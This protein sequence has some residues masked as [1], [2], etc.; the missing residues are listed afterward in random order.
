MDLNG[1]K[2]F[3]MNF[4]ETKANTKLRSSKEQYL[5]ISRS[6]SKLEFNFRSTC[7]INLFKI[8]EVDRNNCKAKK[9]LQS[10]HHFDVPHN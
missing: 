1:S 5:Q 6:N 8:K 7:G 2:N 10:Q 3:V 9:K 4:F